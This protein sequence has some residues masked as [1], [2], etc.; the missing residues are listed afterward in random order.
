MVLTSKQKEELNKA[1]AEYLEKQGY[2]NTLRSFEEEANV[3]A[4]ESQKEGQNG[5]SNSVISD[6]LEKKWVS[7]T[8]LQKKVMELEGELQRLQEENN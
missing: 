7:I 5:K 4:K 6:I 2:T 1:I 8:R 3:N